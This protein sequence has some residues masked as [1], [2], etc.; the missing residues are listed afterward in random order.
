VLKLDG[1]TGEVLWSQHYAGS[2]GLDEAALAIACDSQDNVYFTGR[3]N[4]PNQGV[5]MMTMRLDPADGSIAWS[6]HWGLAAGADDVAWDIVVGADGDPVIAG[7]SIDGGGSAVGV[8][9]R[10]AAADGA[11]VWT[12]TRSGVLNNFA[13]TGSWLALLDGGDVAVCQRGYG[14]TGYDI[15]LD[16]LAADDGA[17]AWSIRYDGATH[18]GD[19]PRHM[20]RNDDGD[21]LVAGVQDVLWNYD[22]ML[23]KF[24]GATGA[25]AWVAPGYDGPPG[26]YDAANAVTIGPNGP[27][28]TGLS[29]GS[30]TGWDMATVGY[31]DADGSIRWVVRYDCAASQS[32]EPRAAAVSNDGKL[33]VSGYGYGNGSG[34]D[35]VTLRY[36]LPVSSAVP[37]PAM[38]ARLEPAF[39]NPFNPTTT[40]AF[41]L[42]AAMDVR[43]AVYGLD[44][45]LVR[46]LAAENRSAGRHT[47]T[48]DGRDE[49]GR[50]LA[51]GVYVGSLEAGGERRTR[52]LTLVK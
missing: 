12:A 32:D 11:T 51:S 18:G 8:V 27:I 28:V 37:A 19:L 44:G 49:A 36:L 52:R 9:H 22:F 29:D 7:V 45:R 47:V 39:P 15:L 24:D 16:R 46:V 42:E 17:A 41:T 33:Y 3:G 48:W 20:V 31:D 10:L 4:L 34:K 2:D 38:A 1:A 30:G 14:S 6:R 21:L 23:V 5:E 13:S 35:H 50:A 43:L 25:T 40:L 26:W